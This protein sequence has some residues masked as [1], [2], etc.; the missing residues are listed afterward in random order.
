MADATVVENDVVEVAQRTPKQIAWG[1]FKRNKVGMISG[2]FAIIFMASAFLAPI[3]TRIIGVNPRKRYEDTLSEYG[4]PLGKWGGV[5]LEHP[6]GLEPGTG[7]DVF[8][9]LLYGARISFTVAIIATVASLSLGMVIGIATGYFKGKVDATVGRLADFLLSFPATFMIIAL[10][11][12]LT[13]RVESTGLAHENSARMVVLILFLV[14]FGWTGF[15]RLVRSQAMSLRE[16]DFVMAAQAM[17]A[18][19][20]RIILKELLPKL[21]P[22]AIVFLSLSLP[23]YIASE[24]TFS[25]LG[26][27]IQAPETSFGLVL[28]D[29]VGYWRDDPAYLIIPCA[30]LIAIVLALNLLGDAVRDALDPKANR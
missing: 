29:A 21:W 15:Y 20:S 2:I 7:R 19:N 14:F 13:Q 9:L 8:S 24:A 5:S 28:S 4:M 27:G 11:I 17:G 18:S 3:I 16:R 22:T 12:P 1:R 25:F 26:V 30:I 10:S 6:F 23:A